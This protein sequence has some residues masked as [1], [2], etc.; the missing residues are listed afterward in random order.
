LPGN[1]IHQT[2][3]GDF[4]LTFVPPPNLIASMRQRLM[5][6][7][8]EHNED[9]NLTLTRYAIERLL[10]RLVQSPHTHLFMLKGALLFRIYP[11]TSGQG[12]HA[13]HSLRSGGVGTATAEVFG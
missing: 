10:Y 7:S 3:F 2:L 13:R 8:R 4:E 5:N 12:S 6:R 1:K 9:F 11:K